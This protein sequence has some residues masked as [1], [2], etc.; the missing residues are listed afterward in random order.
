MIAAR[1]A[2]QA[3]VAFRA[4]AKKGDDNRAIRPVLDQRCAALLDAFPESVGR[5]A[6]GKRSGHAGDFRAEIGGRRRLLLGDG[7]AAIDQQPIES[8]RLA[9][10]HRQP[11]PGAA[12]DE[13]EFG[14]ARRIF[15]KAA[16]VPP[17]AVDQ[18]EI[19]AAFADI[20]P[21]FDVVARHR[22]RIEQPARLGAAGNL[23]SGDQRRRRFGA[24]GARH[25]QH[26]DR[27]RDTGSA[28]C[29]PHHVFFR[30]ATTLRPSP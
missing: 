29:R 28:Q 18:I 1:R 20:D 12:G 22:L 23:L 2:E 16:N 3:D 10:R 21:P 27:G 19:E 6:L 26:H 7:D 14:N 25:R 24:H 5:L 8:R 17:L 4:P 13:L 30:V 11:L 9:G 15:G